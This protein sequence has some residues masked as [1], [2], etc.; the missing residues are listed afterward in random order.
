[1]SSEVK[2]S[3]GILSVGL[4][5]L[6]AYWF[7][8][9]EHSS[10]TTSTHK[11]VEERI[12]L[13]QYSAQTYSDISEVKEYLKDLKKVIQSG[14]SVL[15]LESSE[16]DSS[17]ALA[18]KI[19]LKDEAFLK[20]TKQNGK[21]LHNDMMSIRPAIVSVLSASSK[22]ICKTQSCYQA[23]KYNYVTNATTRAIVNV[24][25]EKVL[26]VT[27]HAGMQPD[28]SLRLRHIAQAIALNAPEVVKELDGTPRRQ[29]MSMANVRGALQ[30]SPCQNSEHLCV[31]P[32][33]SDHKN[34]QALWA[35]VDLT[36][37][38]LAAAKWAGLGK[39]TTPACISERSLQ[40]RY[41]MK[42]FCEKDTHLEQNGWKLSYRLTGSDG[43]EIID[44][45]FKG[46][47]VLA[48][49]K[50]V[51]WHVAYEGKGKVDES[52]DVQMAGRQVEFVK[53]DEG[54]FFFGYN[55]AMGCPMF[56]TSVV[57]PFNGPLVKRLYDEHKK[58]VGFY[59]TQ[60]FRNPKWPMACNYRY[61]NRFEFFN[62]GSFRVVGVNK[63]RGCGEEAIYRPV[64]R[65]DM[66]FTEKE[67]FY[68]YDGSWSHWL[69]EQSDFQKDAKV[70]AEDKYL[71]K[72][73]DTNEKK[74]YYIEPNRGQ[75]HDGSKGDNAT[76]FVTKFKEQ[77][78]DKDLLT[79]GS[80][81]NL[82]EDGVE[83]YVS[84]NESIEDENL[85][86]WYVPRIKNDA[87]AGHEYCWADT[88]IDESGNIEVR[89]FPCVVGPKFV[90]IK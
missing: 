49:A 4:V 3:L 48:S 11:V 66:A 2:I 10:K 72:I 5:A 38:T 22:A 23:E 33:F 57:L 71:Y 67:N 68:K 31:A 50:I 69:T 80:C 16:L 56:S 77:E 59:L 54:K 55:D 15:P 28:I 24:E 8:D 34:E 19:L 6:V 51:D 27:N 86:L 83:R 17:G 61:E 9:E 74:G 29:D 89:T 63:G 32:T 87:R 25:S 52:G 82:D 20:D 58:E 65:M 73:T 7:M 37:L 64:M 90:P 88:V 30:G 46:E 36:E 45:S 76:I 70:Y 79:L 40:N 39:T 44:V 35:I 1:L 26:E 62:D 43:L 14:Q 42:N 85:V 60:D 21:L 41:I 84:A 18:Q 12:I 47:K 53:G 81:C 13:P 78:G 75:F